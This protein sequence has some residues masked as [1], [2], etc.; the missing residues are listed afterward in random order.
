MR[1]LAKQEVLQRTGHSLIAQLVAAGEAVFDINIPVASVNRLRD[2]GA[3]IDW[4]APGTVPA[5]MI[6]VGVTAQPLHPN[7]A[8]LYVDFVLSKEGQA[9]MRF[10]PAVG[11]HRFGSRAGSAD[12]R[13]AHRAGQS[14]SGRSDR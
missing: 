8:R 9:I 3:P 10:S 7:A 5:I 1:G 11:A 4:I 14:K 12:E 13:L 6:G 2:A